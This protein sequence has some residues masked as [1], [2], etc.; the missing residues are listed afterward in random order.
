MISQIATF[1][2]PNALLNWLLPSGG[3]GGEF[4]VSCVNVVSLKGI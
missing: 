3:V 2:V 4:R 1:V